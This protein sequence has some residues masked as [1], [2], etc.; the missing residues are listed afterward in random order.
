MELIYQ[1]G[2]IVTQVC[3]STAACKG[4]ESM[5]EAEQ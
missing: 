1:G 2:D 3:T 4:V 5:P